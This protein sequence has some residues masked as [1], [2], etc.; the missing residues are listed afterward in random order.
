MR[1]SLDAQPAASPRG[2]FLWLLVVAFLT[3]LSIMVLLE[4]L[5]F[6]RPPVFDVLIDSCLLVLVLGP[7]VW[8]KISR[9]KLEQLRR[10]RE[11]GYFLTSRMDEGV[12]AFDRDLSVLSMNE[13]ARRLL[14]VESEQGRRL[15]QWFPFR[16]IDELE[17]RLGSEGA[18]RVTL[19]DG[20]VLSCV[21]GRLVRSDTYLLIFRDVTEEVALQRWH[22]LVVAALQA[23]SDSLLI[24]EADGRVVWVNRAFTELTGYEAAEVF[25]KT[26]AILKSGKTKP[27]VY[28]ALWSTILAGQVWSGEV[29]NRRKDGSEY[30]AGLTIA[31][32]EAEGGERYFIGIH[33][34]ITERKRMVSDMM[35]LDRLAQA[36]VLAV[37]VGHEINNP[38]TYVMGN[39]EL[40]IEELGDAP[41]SS[42]LRSLLEQALEGARRIEKVVQDLRLLAKREDRLR[43]RVDLGEVARRGLRVVEHQLRHRARVQLDLAPGLFVDGDPGRLGQVVINLL[44]N[45]GDAIEVGDAE[46]N[47]IELR[48][49]RDEGQVVL[50]VADTGRG[51][52]EEQIGKIFDPFTTFK[53]QGEGTGLGLWICHEIVREHGGRIEVESEPGR[54]SVFRV[55]L[56]AASDASGAER[57]AAQGGRA[58]KAS[59]GEASAAGEAR[60]PRVLVVDDEPAIGRVIARR[61]GGFD[62]QVVHDAQQAL[63][64]ILAAPGAYDVVLCDLMMPQ[65]T[66]IDLAEA[67]RDVDPELAERFVFMTGG[68]FSSEVHEFVESTSLP[69]LQKPLD[70]DRLRSAIRSLAER[71]G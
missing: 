8:W 21:S 51:I 16:S 1:R 5:P 40:A 6:E 13:G 39:L 12:I 34:D 33:K 44:V 29:I 19:D 60:G 9:P 52:S 54:G 68:A 53:K 61:L 30:V 3:E 49:V 18:F 64:R 59:T 37:G 67:V 48:G 50:E 62:V 25:G 20:R 23:A 58:R 41:S 14:G 36:G 35:K 32:V 7:F 4:W 55:V 46:H 27:E 28:R 22:S 2:E 57:V 43:Q 17:A 24:T 38:L 15:T 69:V 31:P 63:E 10:E 42:E 26:P 70:F 71:R 66:G 11:K 65:V 45:A 56:P 47:R